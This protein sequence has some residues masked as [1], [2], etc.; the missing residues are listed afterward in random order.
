M[1][2]K[3]WRL[4]GLHILDGIEK[5]RRIQSRGSLSCD[6]VLFDAALRNLQT[7]SEATQRLPE[8]LKAVHPE[9]PW[10][11][12][13]GFRNILVHDYLGEIDAITVESIISDHLEPLRTA[14]T[15]MLAL[16]DPSVKS[17]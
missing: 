9:V 12:I 3:P 13:S 1:N 16:E 10:N 17:H 8:E 6:V 7:L 11:D 14:V 15:R 4:Y 5:I 2:R